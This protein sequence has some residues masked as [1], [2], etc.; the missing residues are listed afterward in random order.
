MNGFGN[1]QSKLN[2]DYTVQTTTP[3][4]RLERPRKPW[5]K[6]EPAFDT[7]ADGE[8]PG[9]G[10]SVLDESFPAQ[11]NDPAGANDSFTKSADA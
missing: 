5:E 7:T 9:W 8:R 4:G 3:F 2:A 6:V 10:G 11:D 1:R